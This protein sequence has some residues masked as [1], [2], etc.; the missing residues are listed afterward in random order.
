MVYVVFVGLLRYPRLQVKRKKVL[1][2]TCRTSNH[3]ANTTY[4]IQNI[5]FSI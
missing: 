2:F 4:T 5:Y 3:T 1:S